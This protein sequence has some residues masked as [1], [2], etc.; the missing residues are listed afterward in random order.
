MPRY[1]LLEHT[2]APDDPSGCH[3]DVLLENGD[4]C[5]AWRLARQPAAGEPTQAAVELPPH[6]LVWLTPRSAAVSGGRGWARGIA[7]GHYAGDLPSEAQAPVRIQLLDGALAG[8]LRLEEGFCVL[9]GCTTP[10]GN[11]P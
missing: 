1:A 3:Y 11:G 4:H 9:E 2:G 10:T 6:R 8:R 7:H 5:R